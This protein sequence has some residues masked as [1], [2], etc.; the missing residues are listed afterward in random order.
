[1]GRSILA[2][3]ARMRVRFYVCKP[4]SSIRTKPRHSLQ[5]K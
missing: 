5:C 4:L 3:K 2:K 1:M